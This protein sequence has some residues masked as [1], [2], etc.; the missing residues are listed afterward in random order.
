MR[1]QFLL[2]LCVLFIFQLVFQNVSAQNRSVTGSVISKSTGQPLS[3]ATVL[4]KSTTISA[5]T[6]NAGNFTISVPQ[7][8]KVLIISY[9]GHTTQAITIPPSGIVA[10]QLEASAVA[11]LDE[12]VVVGYGVQRKSVVTG[13]I[14]SV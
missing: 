3:G 7:S 13:A 9:V 4:G 10:V 6:D 11:K 8:T 1:V 5:V 14:S 2:R 12:V